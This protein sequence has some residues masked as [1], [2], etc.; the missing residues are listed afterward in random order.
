[1]KTDSESQDKIL[2]VHNKRGRFDNSKASSDNRPAQQK[3]N[4]S[5]FSSAITPNYGQLKPH[6][7]TCPQCGKNHF[8]TYRRACSA[9]FNCGS[10]D[11]KVK[12]CPNL[13]NA[14]SLKIE[15]S[16]HKPFVNTPQTNKGARPR[17]TQT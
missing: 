9:C 4:R 1:M 2:E 16:V 12:D 6:V 15:G 7:P 14:P 10:F 11:H 13:N 5:Y 8:G 3:Q 17:N